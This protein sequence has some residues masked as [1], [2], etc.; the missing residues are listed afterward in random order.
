M[1]PVLQTTTTRDALVAEVRK[2][3]LSGELGPGEALTENGLASAF[4]VARPTVRSALQ[5]L[6]ARHLV[7][8]GG[9]RSLTVPVLTE[10][11]VRDLF[12]VRT[13]LEVRA[14][15]EIVE[16]GLSLE[17]AEELLAALEALPETADWSARVE[18]HTAF[19]VALVDCAGSPRLSRIYPA[20]QEEMQLCLAQLHAVYPG[21]HDLAVEHRELL[22]VI[23]SGDVD[24]ACEAMRA[25]LDNAEARLTSSP[26][27]H[28]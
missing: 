18:A 21:P 8:A 24:R 15:R 27:P 10:D 2:R 26:S 25:H 1:S 14:V 7:R 19:H 5:V 28:P 20:M 11:D 12:F 6:V 3:I 9:G 4:G 22:E 23:G 17:R 13:P 16:K